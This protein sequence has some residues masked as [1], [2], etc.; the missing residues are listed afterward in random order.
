MSYSGVVYSRTGW[1]TKLSWMLA[2]T[3]M[4]WC[5]STKGMPPFQQSVDCGP[6]V[7]EYPLNCAHGELQINMNRTACENR[8]VCYSNLGEM[9]QRYGAMSNCLPGL[10]CS[11]DRCREMLTIC[12]QRLRSP[13]YMPKRM[14]PTF[15]EYVF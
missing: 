7:T 13:M 15:P 9:C 2:L 5:R 4:F 1:L 11:C 14:K 3:L 12:G 6:S 10:I 8:I